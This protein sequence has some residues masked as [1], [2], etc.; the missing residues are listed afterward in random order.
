MIWPFWSLVFSLYAWQNCIILTPCCPKDGPTGGAG[1]AAPAGRVNFR[2]NLIFLAIVFKSEIRISKSETISHKFEF[3]K[4][5]TFG[6]W[7]F[8]FLSFDIVSNFVLRA[9]NLRIRFSQLGENPAPPVFP[10]QK[11][12][13]GFWL[14]PWSRQCRKCFPK[15]RQT[16]LR[17]L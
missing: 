4:S 15:I 3:S 14:Y 7:L 9:S 12:K 16:G 10:G 13:P 5:E 17:W 8:E 6:F 2:M 11:L 1:L